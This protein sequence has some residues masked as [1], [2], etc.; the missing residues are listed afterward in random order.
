MKTPRPG[1]T[2]VFRGCIWDD[3]WEYD[4]PCV[5]Y[6]P[7]KRYGIGGNSGHIDSMVEDI[8]S[9]IS[10]CIA[11]RHDWTA[12]DL[13]EFEWRGWSPRG[14]ARR[15]NARH[16]E[17]VVGFHATED[18]ELEAKVLRRREQRGPFAKQRKGRK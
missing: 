18:G 5:L 1:D 12:D 8:A 9:D 16:V 15:K 14:F 10:C 6:S 13:R 17:I 11:V 4:A 3:G 2:I 7:V